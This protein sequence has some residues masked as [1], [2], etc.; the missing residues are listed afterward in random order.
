MNKSINENFKI[1][2]ELLEELEKNED[3][4]DKSIQIYEKARSIYK[5]ID[6][7]LKDYKAKVEIISKDE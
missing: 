4:L 5:Q 7:Q 2:E 1:L 3:N 6:Q